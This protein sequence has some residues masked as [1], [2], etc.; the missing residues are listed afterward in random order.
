MTPTAL[1]YHAQVQGDV[2][3]YQYTQHEQPCCMKLPKYS[4]MSDTTRMR[5][6]YTTYQTIASGYSCIFG[7]ISWQKNFYANV[8][9]KEGYEMEGKMHTNAD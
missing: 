1:Q 6:S 5:F 4:F 7:K 8:F 3:M 2:A 9:E